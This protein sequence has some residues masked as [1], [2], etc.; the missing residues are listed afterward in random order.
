MGLIMLGIT[1]TSSYYIL[2]MEVTQFYKE[3]ELI[4]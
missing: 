3:V 4:K 1:N 2:V